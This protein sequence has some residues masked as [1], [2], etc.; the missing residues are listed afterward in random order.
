MT[1]TGDQHDIPADRA[2]R[3]APRTLALVGLLAT[4]A[5]GATWAEV[6]FA[7]RIHA[8][9][10]AAVDGV[11]QDSAGLQ[12]GSTTAGS[13]GADQTTLDVVLPRTVG[14]PATLTSPEGYRGT[15]YNA[16]RSGGDCANAFAPQAPATVT[17]GC[18]G[19]LTA[20]YVRMDDHAVYSSVT[21]L[22][23]AD[24]ATAARVAGALNPA[25][26]ALADLQFQQPAGGLPATVSHASPS[27]SAT[28][29]PAVQR[30]TPG[31]AQTSVP[32]GSPTTSPSPSPSSSPT[33]AQP[34]SQDPDSAATEIH[35]AAIGRTVAIVQS[36][37]ADGRPATAELDTPTWFLSYTVASALAWQTD[38]SKATPTP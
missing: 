27:A 31:T 35:V 24:A 10:Q 28:P 11:S 12:S 19:Y 37:F 7:G 16:F 8:E 25:G 4:A 33:A 17:G 14:F 15:R 22:Y 26:T 32:S 36:A 20:D 21:V 30:G 3:R 34:T 5:A 1:T 2:R 38:Q 29:S 23:Y 6:H 13:G 18:S 9:Q